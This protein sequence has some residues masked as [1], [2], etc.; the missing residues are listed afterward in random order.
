MHTM[1]NS[2]VSLPLLAQL[3]TGLNLNL[4]G[5]YALIR[6]SGAD[7]KAF[8]HTQ[9]T[10]DIAHLGDNDVRLGGYCSAK[11]RLYAIFYT[12][13]EGEEVFLLMHH[14]V[15]ETVIKR[16]RMFVLRM[17]ATLDNVSAQYHISGFVG[18]NALA[19]GVKHTASAFPSFAVVSAR[20]K[21]SR[22]NAPPTG[23]ASPIV[24]SD[25]DR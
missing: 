18:P 17:K 14:S 11:G 19:N 2:E 24:T 22:A 25:G 7:A 5:E 15:A 9:F 3:D 8:L 6:V 23:V 16:L 20:L 4:N 1:N 21:F 13:A 12:Y 10:Q